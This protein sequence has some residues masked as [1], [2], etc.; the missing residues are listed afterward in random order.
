M[1]E[2][3]VDLEYYTNAYFSNGQDAPYKIKQGG[4]I[5]IKPVLVKDYS[6][7]LGCID[8]LQIYKNEI[9][10]INIIQMSYLQFL[11]EVMFTQSEDKDHIAEAKLRTLIS[12]CLGVDRVGFIKNEK[13]KWVIA[14]CDDNDTI[15]HLVSAKE[16]DDITLLILNQNDAHYD[17]RY[18]DPDVREVMKEY[19]EI[20]YRDVNP[21]SLEKR[22]AF[23]S[24]K[25][26]KSFEELG[27]MKIREFELVYKACIDSEIYLATKITEAS[28]KYD[29]KNPSQ[30]PLY[31]PEKD[32]YAE[33][34]S[35]S[36]VLNGKGLQG[37]ENIGVGLE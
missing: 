25:L 29:V 33:I 18:V 28:Y 24:S 30:H 35:D 26:A 31:E 12:L 4:T 9:N 2:S 16:F 34:F 37:A 8:I 11:N 1:I 3:V 6:L 27:E 10:D 7:Y 17:N 21:P 22:K 15:T 36:S 23:V 5:Y 32:A 20:K 14:L 13:G 19:Y